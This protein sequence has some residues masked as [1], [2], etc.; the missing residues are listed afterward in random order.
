M[1]TVENKGIDTKIGGG[2][3]NNNLRITYFSC[4]KTN[5]RDKNS[6]VFFVGDRV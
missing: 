3:L 4:G 2:I 6:L 1:K 5:T